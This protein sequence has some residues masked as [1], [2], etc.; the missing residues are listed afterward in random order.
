MPS[1][2]AV[3][4]ERHTDYSFGAAYSPDGRE[5][6]YFTE[7]SARYPFVT[8]VV[9]NI[10][11]GKEREILSRFIVTVGKSAWGPD[12]SLVF[13]ARTNEGEPYA[14]HRVSLESGQEVMKHSV[15]AD[16]ASPI[17]LSADGKI[18]YY[19]RRINRLEQSLMKYE[20]D[21]DRETE[22]FKSTAT[23]TGLVGAPDSQVVAMS[24]ESSANT[25]SVAITP[26]GQAIFSRSIA[27]NTTIQ[28]LSIGQ[29]L[30]AT[31]KTPAPRL[32][33]TAWR[34]GTIVATGSG[35][36]WW[37]HP[38][39]EEPQRIS[40]ATP[41]AIQSM[42]PDGKQVAYTARA[43]VEPIQIEVW[44]DPDVLGSIRPPLPATNA[45]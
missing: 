11:S 21:A 32:T 2:P 3:G 35:A 22:L 44:V 4:T 36:I 33:A 12:G 42:S 17:H 8:I 28:V 27:S 43:A 39:G 18:V 23:I 24:L 10:D 15:F 14:L 34:D 25:P 9:R 20:L 1:Q 13:V 29:P 37:V 26:A 19:T 5:L 16:Q 40:V 38:T 7:T 30:P 41:I 6:A 45:R 31:L